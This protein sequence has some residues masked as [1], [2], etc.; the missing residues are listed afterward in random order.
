MKNLIFLFLLIPSLAGTSALNLSEITN[1][2]KSG[3][4]QA[5]GQYFDS[6]V[7]VGILGQE[8][9]YNKAKAISLVQQFFNNHRPSSFSQVHKGASPNNDSQY[10]IGNLKS[11]SDSFRVYIYMKMNGGNALIQELK[12]DKE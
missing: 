2:I 8:G 7:E 4:A 1:A 11:G 9:F 12:F 5:L 3:N 10:C 6:S